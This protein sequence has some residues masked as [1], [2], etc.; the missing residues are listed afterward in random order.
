VELETTPL[1]SIVGAKED[2]NAY[3]A[4]GTVPTILDPLKLPVVF[5]S[6]I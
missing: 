5:C 3:E 6:V 2:D 4:L 1:G